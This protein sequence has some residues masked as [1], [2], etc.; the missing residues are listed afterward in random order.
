M[1]GQIDSALV[2][3]LEHPLLFEFELRLFFIC[4]A[5]FF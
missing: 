2:K 4:A 1:I 5:P 3:D